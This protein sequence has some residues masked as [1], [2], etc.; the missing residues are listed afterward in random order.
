ME[1]SNTLYSQGRKYFLDRKYLLAIMLFDQILMNN[2]NHINS[3]YY[4]AISCHNLK[5]YKLAIIWY[6]KTLLL[7]SKH[8]YALQQ[9]SFCYYHLKDY[10]KA[11]NDINKSIDLSPKL[12][13]NYYIKSLILF[14]MKKYNE[15]FKNF[16]KS[17][18]NSL[19]NIEYLN[20]KEKLYD[21]LNIDSEIITL[22]IGQKIGE[23]L[24][25]L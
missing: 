10:N 1:L 8:I 17:N 7:D 24:I 20:H 14:E 13:Y 6:T 5:L 25:N 19:K 23:Y 21:I 3:I 11:L 9:R 15:S 2:K 22:E 4:K 18:V 16:I 12:L